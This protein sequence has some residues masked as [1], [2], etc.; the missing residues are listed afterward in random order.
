MPKAISSTTSALLLQGRLSKISHRATLPKHATMIV[1][2]ETTGPL[3]EVILEDYSQL[4]AAYEEFRAAEPEAK[5]TQANSLLTAIGRN[6]ESEECV[7]CPAIDGKLEGGSE[8]GS[9]WLREQYSQAWIPNTLAA[10]AS[11]L[12]LIQVNIF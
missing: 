9:Q 2:D 3:S 5:K 6:V 1:K 7:L 4:R 10:P 12:F 11:S 8:G